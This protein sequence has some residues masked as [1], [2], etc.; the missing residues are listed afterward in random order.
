MHYACIVG[1][2]YIWS[3]VIFGIH[4]QASVHTYHAYV[5]SRRSLL[6]IY[7]NHNV[8]HDVGVTVLFLLLA[9]RHFVELSAER[10]EGVW[11][12]AR[13]ERASASG[14]HSFVAC[15]LSP[16]GTA[17]Y[18]SGVLCDPLPA[19]DP[20]W[21]WCVPLL[22]SIMGASPTCPPGECTGR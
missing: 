18:F 22:A 12:R 16:S 14:V 21:L 1:Y 5:Y 4:C 6:S 20:S 10:P 8:M 15:S 13:S 19:M 17:A 2:R 11:W 9:L 7:S 3:H